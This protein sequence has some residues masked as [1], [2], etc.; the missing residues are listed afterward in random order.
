MPVVSRVPAA[1]HTP[2]HWAGDVTAFSSWC[3]SEGLRAGYKLGPPAFSGAW[4]SL[5]HSER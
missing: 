3:Y 2:P 4:P 1:S 5:V